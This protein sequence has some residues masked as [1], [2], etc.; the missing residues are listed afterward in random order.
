[1]LGLSKVM[2]KI[3]KAVRPEKYKVK[4]FSDQVAKAKK[5]YGDFAE[6]IPCD[7]YGK[8]VTHSKDND[9]QSIID[10]INQ[11]HGLD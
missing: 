10:D 4:I 6:I 8:K 7:L 9:V 5:E 1:M 11:V 3:M 2:A